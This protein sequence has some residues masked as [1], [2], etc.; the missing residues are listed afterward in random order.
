MYSW[1]INIQW[2]SGH[3][4]GLNWN[5]SKLLFCTRQHYC[6]TLRI[7]YVCCVTRQTCVM[8]VLL[9]LSDIVHVIYCSNICNVIYKCDKHVLLLFFYFVFMIQILIW[10]FIC[11][12][13]FFLSDYGCD[14][15]MMCNSISGVNLFIGHLQCW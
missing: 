2:T 1:G 12:F 10:M 15:N 13:I 9:I 6:F 8:V 3:M 4:M 5:Y 11:L 14:K 7:I